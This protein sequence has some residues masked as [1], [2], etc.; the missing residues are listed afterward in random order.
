MR[1]YTRFIPGEEIDA[2]SQWDFG[3]VDTAARLLAEQAKAR[4]QAAARVQD[5]TLRQEGYAEG[6]VQGRAQALIEAQHQ[7]NEFTQNQG[8][9]AARRLGSV[10]EVA[11]RQLAE[12]EAQAAQGVLEL[13]CELSRQVL[14]H[15]LLVN[16]NVLLPVIREALGL[17]FSGS[18]SA[19]VRLN[20]LDLE[21]LQDVLHAEFAGL[22]LTLLP[23]PSVAK[24]GCLVESAG[25]VVDGSL[26]KRWERAVGRLG[27][28]LP[29]EA[30]D[31]EQ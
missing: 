7:I 9:E 13:A 21:V 18:K 5:E 14:R 27:L 20:P 3:V 24:G 10:I 29:W 15:E 2:V 30:S 16:P 8:E 28:N 1:N 11:Q 4:E 23:D 12:A 22:S 25:T 31:D 6:F 26:E 17:L 19:Q